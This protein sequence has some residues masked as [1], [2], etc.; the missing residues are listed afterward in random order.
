MS[1]TWEFNKQLKTGEAGERLLQEV[2]HRPTLVYDGREHDLLDNLC[3]RIEVKTETRKLEDT[4]N[5]FME[6]VRNLE[7]GAKGGPWQAMHNG[8]NHFVI[9]FPA[10]GVY[11]LFENIMALCREVMQYAS[12]NK[13]E[14]HIIKNT[15]W[16]ASGYVIPRTV[17]KHIYVEYQVCTI[18]QPEGSSLKSS[19]PEMP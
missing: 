13:L 16:S 17:L 1:K 14:P 7:T 12:K 18:T 6:Y 11:F 2:Y 10:S 19:K 4:P 3:N 8:S 15:S 5:F 9:F